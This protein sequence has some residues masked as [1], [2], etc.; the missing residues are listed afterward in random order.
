[1][2][3]R[4]RKCNVFHFM[5]YPRTKSAFPSSPLSSPP[6]PL[7][8]RYK[9]PFPLLPFVVHVL[10]M[11]AL[12]LLLYLLPC[13]RL[14]ARTF[15]RTGSCMFAYNL[16]FRVARYVVWKSI[17]FTLSSFVN[18][19]IARQRYWRI[20]PTSCSLSGSTVRFCE[21]AGGGF[22][23]PVSLAGDCPVDERGED[24]SD[25]FPDYITSYS[26]VQIISKHTRTSTDERP[27]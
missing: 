5:I 24:E 12:L 14:L 7:S 2:F 27:S 17:R 1:M 19:T 9:P 22:Y 15:I 13:R 10:D 20:K 23:P 18:W 16:Y 6:C 4:F 3:T 8:P 11:F 26:E 21:R 25:R